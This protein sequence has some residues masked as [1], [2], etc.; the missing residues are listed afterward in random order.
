MRSLAYDLCPYE[1]GKFGHTGGER[2][3]KVKGDARMMLPSL[4]NPQDF[5]QHHKQKLG[6]GLE[7]VPTGQW[8]TQRHCH[9]DL[10]STSTTLSQNISVKLPS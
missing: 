3:G 2:Y 6:G 7:Q 5:Q 1:K 10:T 9:L 8:R 4:R